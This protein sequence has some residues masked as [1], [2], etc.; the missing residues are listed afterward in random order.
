MMSVYNPGDTGNPSMRREPDPNRI[1]TSGSPDLFSSQVLFLSG[2]VPRSAI[3]E[4]E[5]SVA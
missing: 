4:V 2:S 1:K 3:G 5:R